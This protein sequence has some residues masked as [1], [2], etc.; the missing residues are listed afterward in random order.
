MEKPTK[1]GEPGR[2]KH[3]EKEEAG[4]G[5]ALAIGSEGASSSSRSSVVRWPKRADVSPAM[6][7]ELR[8]RILAYREVAADLE[9]RIEGQKAQIKR[10]E[11]VLVRA[12]AEVDNAKEEVLK[13][14]ERIA[15]QEERIAIQKERM[16]TNEQ[17]LA[18][19]S[20]RCRES[21]QQV[22]QR[23]T[24]G[25]AEKEGKEVEMQVGWYKTESRNGSL[26]QIGARAG[27]SWRGRTWRPFIGVQLRTDV[28]L[29]PPQTTCAIPLP[30]GSGQ[31]LEMG[32]GADRWQAVVSRIAIYEE[33]TQMPSKHTRFA[34]GAT[35]RAWFGLANKVLLKGL[36]NPIEK[37]FHRLS[38]EGGAL[39]GLYTLR[40][41]GL[42]NRYGVCATPH[43]NSS[44]VLTHQFLGKAL[45][46]DTD[47][48]TSSGSLRTTPSI[49][50]GSETSEPAQKAVAID[51]AANMPTAASV[52]MA[53]RAL[54][55]GG[56]TV[57]DDVDG[58]CFPHLQLVQADW[59]GGRNAGLSFG[60]PGIAS[61]S[62]AVLPLLLGGILLLHF[63]RYFARFA[64]QRRRGCASSAPTKMTSPGRAPF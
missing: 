14:R 6:E 9:R 52:A 32:V 43:K 2:K 11:E 13:N 61:P 47:V 50:V 45:A 62:V 27:V 7:M 59:I 51:P 38:P 19:M 64:W 42:Q 44:L 57:M 54:F 53:R 60:R 28:E 24:R 3:F 46:M 29:P 49:L 33:A 35:G 21:T 12:K 23:S 36:P 15:V 26:L 8:D 40:S 63:A 30:K 31:T 25:M 22:D 55:K 39:A 17:Q 1:S 18:A 48:A 34:F 58:T 41:K 10:V 56:A 16:L 37:A 20:E 5:K 4:K